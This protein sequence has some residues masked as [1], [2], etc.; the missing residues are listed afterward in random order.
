MSEEKGVALHEDQALRLI[1]AAIE[2]GAIRFPFS[3]GLNEASVLEKFRE[4]LKNERPG[5]ITY[6]EFIRSAEVSAVANRVAGLARFDALYILT[7]YEALTTGLTKKE[8]DRIAAA[9]L[10]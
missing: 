3:G 2:A 1:L 5:E 7:L 6:E 8:A 4:M 10:N 9:V